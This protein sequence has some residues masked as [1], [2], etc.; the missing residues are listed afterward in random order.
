MTKYSVD[1]I[2]R[3]KED[4]F[5]LYLTHAAPHEPYQ[6]RNPKSKASKTSK[7]REMI[8]ALDDSV[9]AIVKCLKK[10]KLEK[11]T[12]IVFCSDNGAV[13]LKGLKTNGAWRGGKGSLLEGGHRVP[14]I[15]SYPGKVPAGQ[16]NSNPL[17]SV[18]IFPSLLEITNIKLA[19]NHK[20]DGL[21]LFPKIKGDTKAAPR[22]LHWLFGDKWA[23]RQGAWKLSGTKG[24]VK[25]LVN[26]DSDSQERNN[27]LSKYPEKVMS[28]LELHRDWIKDVG[29]R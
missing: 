8:E 20:I 10:N 16:V 6:A 13:N 23:I 18:D 21:S 27:L 15:V 25:T 24:Q 12:L 28:L 22:N 17:M 11:K 5:F 4:P 14:L 3:N 7:Y 9:G 2:E 29:D 1:F 19:N 26:I